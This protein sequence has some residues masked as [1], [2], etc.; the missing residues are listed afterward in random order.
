MDI[1]KELKNTFVE[2]DFQ[3]LQQVIRISE[4]KEC[5]TVKTRQIK[6]FNT[7]INEKES[8]ENKKKQ[9]LAEQER[10][11]KVKIQ[12]EVIDLTEKGIDEDVKKYLSLGPDF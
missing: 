2:C 4:E 9:Q 10:V 8:V 7:L 1:L 5:K 12:K 3:W 11:K 6:K